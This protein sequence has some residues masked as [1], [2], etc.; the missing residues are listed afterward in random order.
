MTLAMHCDIRFAAENANFA[1][2]FVRRGLILEGGLSWTLPRLAGLGNA[3]DIMLTGRKFGAD[4]ALRLG[5]VQKVFPK[6]TLMKEAIA[7][8][9]DMAINVPPGSSHKRKWSL[10]KG[11]SGGA[12]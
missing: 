12:G 11:T 6:E 2:A 1:A 10:R 7:Y 8:A 4:E 3:M 9:T 5:L